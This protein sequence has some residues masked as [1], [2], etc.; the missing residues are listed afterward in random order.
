MY[1]YRGTRRSPRK[2]VGSKASGAARPAYALIFAG[3]ALIS[4]AVGT[5]LLYRRDT[6]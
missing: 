5:V 6:N 3:Y 2:R 1:A 4:L